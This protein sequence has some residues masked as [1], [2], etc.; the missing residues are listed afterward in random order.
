ML[1]LNLLEE[2]FLNRLM[3]RPQADGQP[4]GLRRVVR[5]KVGR[6]PV[7]YLYWRLRRQWRAMLRRHGTGRGQHKRGA[8]PDRHKPRSRPQTAHGTS[9]AHADFSFVDLPARNGSR[10]ATVAAGRPGPPSSDRAS[11]MLVNTT[12]SRKLDTS[13]NLRRYTA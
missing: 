12:Q 8:D 2:L 6:R 4:D 11:H 5:A 3:R 1:V 7:P 10:P 9:D 13:V